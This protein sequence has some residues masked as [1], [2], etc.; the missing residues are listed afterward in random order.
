MEQFNSKFVWRCLAL[1]CDNM[2]NAC[3]NEMHSMHAIYAHATNTKPFYT[4]T[5]T[6][7]RE[8]KHWKILDKTEWS[9]DAVS[10]MIQTRY[11]AES[12]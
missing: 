8:Q 12:T 4:R 9:L 1:R 5:R 10:V 7:D 6:R 3:R 2:I 11:K